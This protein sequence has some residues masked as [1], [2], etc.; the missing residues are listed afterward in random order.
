M[1]LS[2]RGPNAHSELT[3]QTDYFNI[4]LSG[5]VLWQQGAKI[6][7]QPHSYKHHILLINGD[8]FSKRDDHSLSDTE[9]L[10]RRIDECNDN[11]VE[12]LEMFRSLEGPFSIFYLNQNT[13]KLYFLRDILGRQSLLLARSPD[14]DIILSSVLAASKRSKC[15]ELPP[16]GVFCMNLNTEEIQLHPWQ[17]LNETHLEQLNDSQSMFEKDIE[18][19]STIASPWLVKE[20]FDSSRYYNFEDI[21]RDH[22]KN[23]SNEIFER[24]LDNSNVLSICDEVIMRLENS[25]SDRIS[26]TPS[27]CRECLKLKSNECVHARVGILFSGGIDCTILAVLTDKRLDSN[28][29]IDLINVSFEKVNRSNS[30]IAPIDYNTP[31]R[32]SARDSLEELKRMNPNR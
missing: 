19:K 15:L 13:S 31:D 21:L 3:I 25:L 5:F 22:I 32:I 17:S 14:G 29:P 23:T 20:L 16:I 8:I 4:L 7:V 30:K 2:N 11:E 27:V 10:T 24:L 1:L 6:C 9:W 28:Q 18:I 12:L 26:A